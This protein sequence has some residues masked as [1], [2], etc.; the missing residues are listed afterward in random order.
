MLLALAALSASATPA[1]AYYTG[2]H[3]DI[4]TDAMTAEGFGPDAAGVAQVNNW[5]VDF[6]ENETVNPFSGHADLKTRLGALNLFTESWSDEV[7][8]AAERG[9][10]DSSTP[11][12][13]DTAG[14]TREWDRLRRVTWTLSREA[15][16]TRDALQLLGVL[17]ISLHQVQDFYTHTNWIEPQRAG[18]AE[19]PLGSDGP[20]WQAR[21][22]GSGPTWFDVPAAARD[23][24]TIYTAATAEGR[25]QHGEWDGSDTGVASDGNRTL[26]GTMAKDWHGRPLYLQSAIA[27]Y[28]ATRQWLRAVR[29]W[30]ADEACWARAQRYSEHLRDLRHD[31]AGSFG[32]SRYAGRWQGQGDPALGGGVSG[33]GSSLL[34]LRA[35]IRSYFKPRLVPL[36]LRG[37]TAFRARFEGYTVF[38]GPNPGRVQ[39][40]VTRMADTEP[41]GELGPVP[42]SQDLQRSMRFVVLRVLRMEGIHLGDPVN[43]H[44][45]LYARARIAGQPFASAVIHGH[46]SFSFP[47]PHE[48]TTWLK[49]VPAVPDEGEPVESIEVEVATGDVRSAGTDD[50]VLLRLGQG[51]RFPLDKRLYD[52]FERGDRDTYSVPIDAAVQ[53]G[54][55]VGDITRVQIEKARDGIAGGWRLAG[56]RLRV[57][58]RVVYSNRRVDRWLEDD[59]R[60]WTAPDFA[61]RAPRGSKVPVW[62]R[63]DEDDFLFGGDDAGDVNPY[64][65]RRT[66]SVGY[67]PGPP[68]E[69]T[70]TGGGLLG[71]RLDDG[72][73]ATVRY[74]LETITPEPIRLLPAPPRPSPPPPPI[75]RPDLLVTAFSYSGVTVRNAGPGP[76]GPFRLRAADATRSAVQSFAGLAAG[77]SETRGLTGL[78]CE[79]NYV[80]AVDDLAQ[81]GETDE[82]NNTRSSEAVVC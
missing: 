64:D 77:A 47:D 69:R 12:L 29:A 23:Q 66:V 35:V 42:S 61:R 28:F 51:L 18:G 76:A 44:A 73:E 40:L 45:D 27:A 68:L 62:L 5:F 49:A 41:V 48:P 58:G 11:G 78:A 4:T 71:G 19:V 20:G 9:H 65:R 46:D 63:L 70:T 8:D 67:A 15:C 60:T 34:N 32:I 21:G 54:M 22:F 38:G 59:R 79:G 39:G 81:V 50:D 52:D 16:A 82:T 57:N 75:A 10:F 80:A 26:S 37:R 14:M 72:G 17:G 36:V 6:Y 43:D 53:A 24:V 1:G 56:V 74:R 2:P 30:V 55:R 7:V 3:A 33:P 13:A 25:R 31:Q